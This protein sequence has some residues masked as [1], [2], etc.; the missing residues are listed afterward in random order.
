MKNNIQ[1]NFKKLI[2]SIS[3]SDT[4]RAIGK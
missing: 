4:N 3:Q 2:Y 1:A